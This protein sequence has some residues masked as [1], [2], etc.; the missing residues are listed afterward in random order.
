VNWRG[1]VIAGIAALFIAFFGAYFV[2]ASQ[3]PAS[4]VPGPGFVYGSPTV[5][6]P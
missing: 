5:A 3:N 1:L 2:V 4:S 6:A